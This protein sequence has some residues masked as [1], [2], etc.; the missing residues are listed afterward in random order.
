MKER[1]EREAQLLKE[2]KV[3][4]CPHI[5]SDTTHLLT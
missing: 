4:Q 5:A 2:I 1:E 3:P